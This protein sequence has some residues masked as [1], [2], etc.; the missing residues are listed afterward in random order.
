MTMHV[1]CWAQNLWKQTWLPSRYCIRG[2]FRHW[3][4]CAILPWNLGVEFKKVLTWHV[5]DQKNQRLPLLKASIRR[6]E[7]DWSA[8]G[9]KFPPMY[10]IAVTRRVQCY[11]T[12]GPHPVSK[13]CCT[14]SC[15]WFYIIV[16]VLM[17][18]LTISKP[19]IDFWSR[20]MIYFAL[21]AECY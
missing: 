6:V 4:T 21:N 14:I 3:L 5:P 15:E 13:Q 18:T 11:V 8:L 12:A 9:R 1:N 10:S 2:N 20:S 17:A 16:A 7:K 19:K